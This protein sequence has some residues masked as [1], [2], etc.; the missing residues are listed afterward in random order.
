MMALRHLAMVNWHL[1]DVEDVEIGGHAGVFG[2]NR[3]G[4]STILD[5]AQVVLTGGN[6]PTPLLFTSQSKSWGPVP[7]IPQARRIDLTARNIAAVTIDVR[8]ARVDCSVDLHVETDGPITIR[9]DRC[10]RTVHAGGGV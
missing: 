7:S 1:F 10:R 8:R 5:M 4:K 9:L 6:L 3:S 2:E